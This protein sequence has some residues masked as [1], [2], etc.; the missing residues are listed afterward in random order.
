MAKFSSVNQLPATGPLAMYSVKTTL[1]AAGWT[2][3]KSGDG[4]ALYSASGDIITGGGAVAGGLG[5]TRAYFTVTDASTKVCLSFQTISNT[6]YRVKYSETGAMAGGSPNSTTTGTA[7]DE[8]VLYGAGT[9][10]SPTGTQML[11]TDNSY[12]FHVVANSTAQ[13]SNGTFPFWFGCTVNATGVVAS[14]FGLE[15]MFTGTFHPLDVAP[16]AI[17]TWYVAT[18][19]VATG[20]AQ[21]ADTNFYA[22][23]WV[24]YGLG[25][26]AFKRMC[27]FTHGLPGSSV[28]LGGFGTSNMS[29]GPYATEDQPVPLLLGRVVAN[30]TLPGP[31]G[32]CSDYKM[33]T[34]TARSYPS[35]IL[36]ATNAYVYYGGLL[37]F[38]PE[39]VSPSL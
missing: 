20:W 13:A 19:P 32:T 18:G 37:V 30:G 16:R 23:A 7:T 34:N 29:T 35:T 22:R 17:I 27:M 36:N 39:S 2:V 6:T 21:D 10:A 3:T 14:F 28:F 8:Q 26:A 24:A 9:D 33:S 15:G 38:W 25:A 5:N 12:R 11:H 1:V 4:L 31:K